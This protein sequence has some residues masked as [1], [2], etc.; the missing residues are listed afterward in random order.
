VFEY[1]KIKFI[2]SSDSTPNSLG[3]ASSLKFAVVCIIAITPD[4]CLSDLKIEAHVEEMI[5]RVQE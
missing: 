4:R 3:D 2:S 5:A 1:W